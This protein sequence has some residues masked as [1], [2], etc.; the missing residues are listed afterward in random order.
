MDPLRFLTFVMN[1]PGGTVHGALN[2][3]LTHAKAI[4]E[5]KECIINRT[6]RRIK[7]SY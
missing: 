3:Y 6:I 1:S 4:D 5:Q 7:R 2:L